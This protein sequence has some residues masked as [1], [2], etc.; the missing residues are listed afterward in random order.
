MKP[1]PRVD[2]DAIA[3]LYDTQPYR[4]KTV[5]PE[6]VAFL[7]QYASAETL[8]VLDIGCGTGNQL[9]AN[10]PLVP[11]A[12]LVGLDRFLGMLRQARS[13]APDIAWAQADGGA[14]PWQDQSFDFVRALIALS[15][16]QLCS[17]VSPGRDFHCWTGLVHESPR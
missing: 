3:H 1:S 8:S 13:K 15:Q 2:Y 10:R 9:G 16:E 17:T 12:H 5:E 6:L 11:H 4:E 14:L 7:E